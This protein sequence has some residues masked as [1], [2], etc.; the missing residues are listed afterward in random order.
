MGLADAIRERIDDEAFLWLIGKWLKAGVLNTDGTVI[1]PETGTP[2]GGIVS[3]VLSNVYLHY[4]LDLWFEK[5]VRPGCR[6]DAYLCRY[7]DD[8][9]CLFRRKEDAEQFYQALGERLGKFGLELAAEK[10]QILSFSRFRKWEKSSF[11]FLGFEFRWGT[12]TGGRDMVLRRT[13]PKKLR[14]A[15]HW[16][17]SPNG[18]E[19]AVIFR[20][21]GTSAFSQPSCAV[22]TITMGCSAIRK[23]CAP[24]IMRPFGLCSSG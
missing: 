14:S 3:P 12:F 22:T 9:V 2:Q 1:Q 17:R 4:A 20:S 18:V 23:V 24:I 6:A 16:P 11:V 15:W 8:F 7:A 21:S 13:A 5:V 10:T 19:P